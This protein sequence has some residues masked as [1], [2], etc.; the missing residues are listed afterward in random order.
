MPTNLV[1]L[2]VAGALDGTT[3]G[4]INPVTPQTV[5]GVRVLEI[6]GDLG[7]LRFRDLY[8]FLAGEQTPD[9]FIPRLDGFGTDRTSG[10]LVPI[11]GT[12]DD[13][14]CAVVGPSALDDPG[15]VGPFPPPIDPRFGPSFRPSA[16]VGGGVR[17]L[18]VPAAGGLR[19][20]DTG[21]TGPYVLEWNMQ[22][23]QTGLECV[24]ASC[25]ALS[26]LLEDDAQ[27]GSECRIDQVTG[28]L[29]PLGEGTGY[30]IVLT[31]VGF[32]S[33]GLVGVTLIP[34]GPGTPLT[35]TSIVVDSDTQ[36]TVTFDVSVAVGN[37]NGLYDLTLSD[38]PEVCDTATGVVSVQFA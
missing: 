24:L 26:T 22:D 21:R 9:Q 23:L 1:R 2:N 20:Y 31:G 28:D 19:F 5:D 16:F 29:G 34:Q 18:F 35:I 3:I 36:I 32:A 6:A 38:G 4:V 15:N 30:Q 14:V 10:L 33:I 17:N 27:S 25:C 13:G 12:S 37:P 8:Q 7:L 11:E